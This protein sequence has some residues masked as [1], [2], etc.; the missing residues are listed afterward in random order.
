M[1]QLAIGSTAVSLGIL[2]ATFMGGLCLGSYL[3]PRLSPRTRAAYVHF[4]RLERIEGRRWLDEEEDIDAAQADAEAEYAE[5]FAGDGRSRAKLLGEVCGVGD[6]VTCPE[7][8]AEDE[9]EET[10]AEQ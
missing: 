6:E 8:D 5:V 7:L 3:L 10:G 2:L 9:G 4:R 1:L